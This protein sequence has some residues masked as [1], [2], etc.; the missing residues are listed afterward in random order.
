MAPIGWDVWPQR[1]SQA[2]MF[3]ALSIASRTALPPRLIEQL[4]PGGVI[5]TDLRGGFSGAMVRLHKIDDDTVEGRC[6]SH[7]AAFMP[8]RR[9]LSYPLRQGAASPL[10][11]DRRNPQQGSTTTDPR[12]ITEPRGLRFLV[13]LQL[14][15]A[16]ADMFVSD[17]EV[18]VS[19]GDWSWSTAALAADTDGT[20]PLAQAG[21]QP[22]T[23][24]AIDE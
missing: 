9:Q 14:G 18:V 16:H 10:V 11:M 12:L 1:L 15:G 17:G 24:D 4:Q 21:S 20:H 6:D 22:R 5:V 8:M 23:A 2:A 13:E 19:A 7:D 3:M